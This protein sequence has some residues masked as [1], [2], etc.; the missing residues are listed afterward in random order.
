MQNWGNNSVNTEKPQNS[1]HIWAK[2]VYQDSNSMRESDY[3]IEFAITKKEVVSD[4]SSFREIETA[5]QIENASNKTESDYQTSV[6][7]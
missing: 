1:E 2:S 5:Y 7:K 4:A 6:Y 3:F